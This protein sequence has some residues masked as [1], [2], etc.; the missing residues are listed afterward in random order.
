MMAGAPTYEKFVTGDLK[1]VSAAVQATCIMAGP[2][3]LMDE[4]FVEAMRRGK[5]NSYSYQ[6]MGKLYD[7][8]P[9]LYREASPITHFTKDTGPILFLTGALD[10]PAR[11]NAGMEK[12]KSLGVPTKQ[13]VL[14]DAKHGCCMQHPWFEQCVDAV[15]AWFKTYLK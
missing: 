5:E 11:D 7:D 15:D 14:A 1:D 2:T 3:D 4:K 10:N 6:W 13:V 8:S 12:L 9:D